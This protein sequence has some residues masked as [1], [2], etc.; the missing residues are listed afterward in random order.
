MLV[1]AVISDLHGQ[2]AAAVVFLLSLAE[3]R[4]PSDKTPNNSPDD[5]ENQGNFSASSPGEFFFF[6]L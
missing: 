1:G 4:C 6:P 2:S 3:L 5:A